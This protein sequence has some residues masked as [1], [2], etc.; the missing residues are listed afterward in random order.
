[1]PLRR[2]LTIRA[3]PRYELI[4]ADRL[5]PVERERHAERRRDDRVRR[6]S[7]AWRGSAGGTPVGR[8][9]ALLFLTLRD[10]GLVPRS[11]LEDLGEDTIV[12]LDP[13]RRP[14][15]RARRCLRRR[16]GCGR[17]LRSG[18]RRYRDRGRRR[19]ARW[20]RCGTARSFG[21]LVRG[22]RL[23]ALRLRSQARALTRS[24]LQGARQLDTFLGLVR[25]RAHRAA[26]WRRSWRAL[27]PASRRS[28]ARVA[29]A[30]SAAQRLDRPRGSVQALCEPGLAGA[31]RGVPT[32]SSRSRPRRRGARALKLAA[33][34]AGLCR[35]D[36]L[37]VYFVDLDG[38]ARGRRTARR[39]LQRVERPRGSVHGGGR[40]RRAALVGRRP[41]RATGLGSWREWLT[42]R[43]ARYLCD[44][45]SAP[46]SG[47]E[48]WR[49]ALERI[50]LDGVDPEILVAAAVARLA[51][52]PAVG[53]DGVSEKYVLPPT[54]SSD[55]PR[56]PAGAPQP[57][58][59]GQR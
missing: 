48:P 24:R 2:D 37:V 35:P 44:A 53:A 19:S 26:H 11:T 10:P 33:T 56:A 52:R 51:R 47:V 6:H 54:S 17:R 14:R 3:S 13:R 12:A 55:P 39:P 18:G 25:R 27:P 9:L 50:R 31:S 41:S 45:R 20:R 58:G 22:A 21:S 59:P 8:S 1:M 7:C 29:I 30:C 36:K 49:Y 38:S 23:S 5:E 40:E 32:P 16:A 42:R 43:L 34:P 4:V 15:G 28:V 57:T 46:G